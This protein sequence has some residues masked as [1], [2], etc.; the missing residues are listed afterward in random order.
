MVARELAFLEYRPTGRRVHA[1]SKNANAVFLPT[2]TGAIRR[3]V[4]DD[5][6]PPPVEGEDM[7]GGD[8][9]QTHLRSL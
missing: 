2:S 6:V 8:E 4:L 9:V 7:L 5:G 1:I 3:L